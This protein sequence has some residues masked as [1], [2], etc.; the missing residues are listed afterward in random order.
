MELAPNINQDRSYSV[1][2]NQVLKILEEL[3]HTKY[4][5]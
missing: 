3:N 4:V 1:P 5:F 2:Q